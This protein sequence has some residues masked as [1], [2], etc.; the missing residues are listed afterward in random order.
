MSDNFYRKVCNSLQSTQNYSAV[1]IKYTHVTLEH[2]TSLKS[3]EYICSNS[4]QYIVWVRIIDFSFMTKIIRILS[5]DHVQ[6]RYFVHFL[7]QIYQNLIF[8]K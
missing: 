6:W 7:P 8:D 2:K 1:T 4:Q 5:K 3:L